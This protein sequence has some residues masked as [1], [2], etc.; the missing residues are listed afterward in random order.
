MEMTYRG[1]CSIELGI[2]SNGTNNEIYYKII[3]ADGIKEWF[4]TNHA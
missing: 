2:A 1:C 4:Y 3:C